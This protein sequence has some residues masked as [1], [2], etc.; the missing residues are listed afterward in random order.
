VK[1]GIEIGDVVSNNAFSPP[2]FYPFDCLVMLDVFTT[3]GGTI[4]AVIDTQTITV[5]HREDPGELGDMVKIF[6]IPFVCQEDC[7]YRNNVP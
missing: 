7:T 1:L 4:S 2:S 6:D 3:R 5:K